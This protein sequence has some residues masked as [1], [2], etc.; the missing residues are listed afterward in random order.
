MKTDTEEA[1]AMVYLHVEVVMTRKVCVQ[2]ELLYQ[3][4]ACIKQDVL[5]DK[6]L[7]KKTSR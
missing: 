2:N 4:T 6:S 3:V 7:Y 1:L 5:E